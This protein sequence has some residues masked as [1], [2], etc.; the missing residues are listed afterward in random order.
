MTDRVCLIKDKKVKEFKIVRLRERE[1]GER[2]R[3]RERTGER[4]QGNN[5][6]IYRKYF[7]NVAS[8]ESLNSLTRE[9]RKSI[10]KVCK[11]KFLSFPLFFSFLK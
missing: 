2:E 4:Y 9:M 8:Y 7:E 10:E 6:F 5:I 11:T 3:E 1:T